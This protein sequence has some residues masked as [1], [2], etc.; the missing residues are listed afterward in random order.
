MEFFSGTKILLD[1]EVFSGT[2]GIL[3]KDDVT[4]YRFVYFVNQKSEAFSRGILIFQMNCERW[5]KRR[6]VMMRQGTSE[7]CHQ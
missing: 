2:E 7:Q 1:L 4:P 3:Y 6:Q 5:L